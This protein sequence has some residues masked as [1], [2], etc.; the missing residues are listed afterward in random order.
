K[1]GNIMITPSGI[2]KV[3]DFGLAK[4]IQTAMQT[5]AEVTSTLEGTATMGAGDFQE[6]RGD[7]LMGSPAYM[8]PEQALHKPLDTRSDVFSFG[9]VMYEMLAGR[10]AFRGG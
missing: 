10:H 6:T 1:P 9:T 2:V 7:V 4:V 5:D 8:S 3:L